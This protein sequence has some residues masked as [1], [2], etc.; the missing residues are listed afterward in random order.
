MMISRLGS[1]PEPRSGDES[2][3][4]CSL[5]SSSGLDSVLPWYSLEPGAPLVV[6]LKEVSVVGGVLV[7]D[8]ETGDSATWCQFG[9]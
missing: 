4:G 2:M 9:V 6:C 3:V 8:G 7:W 5:V 1:L